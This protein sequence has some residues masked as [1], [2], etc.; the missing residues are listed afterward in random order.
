MLESDEVFLVTSCNTSVS[1]G[2]RVTGGLQLDRNPFNLGNHF[3][4]AIRSLGNSSDCSLDLF[5]PLGRRAQP[6]KF[7]VFIHPWTNLII[8]LQNF[9]DNF[10]QHK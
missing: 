9:E 7:D 1:S 3:E 10:N 2:E 6:S 4:G 5:D 8:F